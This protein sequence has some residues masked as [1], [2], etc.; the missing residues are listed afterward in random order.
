MALLLTMIDACI[1][2]ATIFI[3]CEL[4]QRVETAFEEIVVDIEQL[5]WYLLPKKLKQTLPIV[6]IIVQQPVSLECFGSISCNRDVFKKVNSC[7]H[8]YSSL[9]ALNI[10]NS[11]R[12]SKVHSHTT[13][14]CGILFK[15]GK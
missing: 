12:L 1:A 13:Q 3:A 2:F 11:Y 8:F 15:I 6:I 14:C 4:S 9:L 10:S 7:K 5:Q